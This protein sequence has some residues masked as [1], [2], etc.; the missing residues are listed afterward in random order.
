MD[1]TNGLLCWTP[2]TDQVAVVPWPDT[3][4]LSDAYTCTSLAWWTHIQAMTFE[5]RKAEVF[6]DA[7]HLIVRDNIPPLA[8]HKALLALDEYRDGLAIDMQNLV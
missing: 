5:Q 1:V 3:D 7:V 8:V 2:G 4:Q 6:I